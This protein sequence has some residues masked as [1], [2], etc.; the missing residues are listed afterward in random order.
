MG[1]L[2]TSDRILIIG[3]TGFIGKH[4]AERCLNETSNVTC[5]GLTDRLDKG[6]R[7]S[8]TKYLQADIC[9]KDVLKSVLLHKSFDY[10]FNLGGTQGDRI[11]FYR[12]YEFD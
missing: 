1:I 9:N 5:L 12:S 11:S 8:G 4:L 3:G 2:S 6:H 10:V 7:L